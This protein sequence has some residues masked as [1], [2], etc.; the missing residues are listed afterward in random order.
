MKTLKGYRVLDV[1]CG[2]GDAQTLAL[3]DVDTV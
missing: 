1:A 2:S 3:T